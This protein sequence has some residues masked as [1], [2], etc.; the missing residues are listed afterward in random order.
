M[1]IFK[2]MQAQVG[3]QAQ[4]FRRNCLPFHG[5]NK[6]KGGDTDS[7][8]INMVTEEM[9]IEI[10]INDLDQSH[11]I[12]D[13]KTKKKEKPIIVKFARYSL[14]HSIFKNKKLL[15]RKGVSITEILMKDRMAKPKEAI[16]T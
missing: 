5:I 2:K 7:I 9:D 3:K 10:L 1:M 14:R 6:E 8:I 12:G 15:K 16:E 11:R 13:P 4:Y